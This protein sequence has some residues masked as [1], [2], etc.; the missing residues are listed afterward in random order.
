MAGRKI[1]IAGLALLLAGCSVT[2]QP[3]SEED[4]AG[5]TAGNL[6]AL[7]ARQAPI[8]GP[9]SLYEAM[10]RALKYNL[11]YRVEQMKEALAVSE[12]ALSGWE[13]LPKLVASGEA[14]RRSNDPGGRSVSLLTGIESLE[15]SR[16][17][18]RTTLTGDLTFSWNILDFGLSWVRA[19]QAADKVLIA[20]ERRR[21]A[22]NRIMEDVRTA[23]WRAASGQRLS[24]ALARLE[25]R[26]QKALRYARRMARN[27]E[28]TPL[29]ALTYERELVQIRRQIRQLEA[30]LKTAR[31]QLAALMNVPPGARFRLRIPPQKRPRAIERMDVKRMIATALRNRPELR[32]AAYRQRINQAE[33]EAAMLELLPG[34]APFLSANVDANDLLYN[35]NWVTWGAK[36]SWNL[37]RLFRYPARRRSIEAREKLLREQALALTMAVM[38]QVHIARV[39]YLARRR[40]HD[41]AREYLDVQQ[42]ILRQVKAARDTDAASEQTLIREQM[43]TL[44]ARAR[45]DVAY[46]ELQNAVAG[47]YASMGLDPLPGVAPEELSVKALAARLKAAWER[48]RLTRLASA[49]GKQG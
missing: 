15:P 7:A 1:I 26:V 18:E 34:I 28:T 45:L 5:F 16:S 48:P 42:R 49:S 33:A 38:T 6:E 19:R 44:L 40:I 29:T 23:F 14:S 22:V 24:G 39:R 17:T 43:N 8:T 35:N 4:I 46:A 21:K 31:V 27:G 20:A 2:P 12:A 10:A 37:M 41:T 11:D 30:E 47:V 13:M 9:V 3:L 32:E 25:R 36:A